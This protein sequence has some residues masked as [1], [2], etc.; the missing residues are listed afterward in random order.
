[1]DRIKE[2]LEFEGI[3]A[4]DEQI[5]AL[6]T[7]RNLNPEALSDEQAVQIVRDIKVGTKALAT[8]NGNVAPANQKPKAP[9]RGRKNAKEVSFK[10]S[11][12]AA[13]KET[14]GDMASMEAVIRQNK[15]QYVD[16]RANS[17]A[18]EIANTSTEVVE[19]LTE[20]LLEVKGSPETFH[21]IG[22][23][24]SAVLFPLS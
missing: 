15:Q 2:L 20:K 21:Q 17:L 1:M 6:I 24:I 9:S 14:E 12:V 7:S 4:T 8:T 23:D 13:A 16:Y 18:D 3:Q 11:I 22:S 10:D 19:A 5:K